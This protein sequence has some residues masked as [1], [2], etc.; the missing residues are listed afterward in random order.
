MMS[1]DILINDVIP[2][3]QYI[4]E[5][6][7]TDFDY[8]FPILKAADLG[9]YRTAND[10]EPDDAL[11][12]LTLNSDYTV[13]GEGEDAGGTVSMLI[14]IEAGDRITLQREM[15]YERLSAY[16]SG[17]LFNADSLD[18]DL[19]SVI[20][21]MQQVHAYYEKRFLRYENTILDDTANL[22]LPT[23]DEG[24]IW[25]KSVDGIAAVTLEENPNWSALRSE[26][27]NQGV[28]VDGSRIVG[29]QDSTIGSTTV[30]NAIQAYVG[31]YGVDTGTTN[32]I[33]ITLPVFIGYRNGMRVL[34]K[35]ANTNT[36]PM[37]ININ[38]TGVKNIKLQ[39]GE[40]TAGNAVVEDMI[41]ELVYDSDFGYFILMNSFETHSDFE[42]GD[43]KISSRAA[44]STG[45]VIMNDGTIGSANSAATTLKSDACK[46]LFIHLWNTYSDSLAPVTGGRGANAEADW[47]AD[48]DIKLLRVAGR[49]IVAAGQGSGLTNR[50]KGTIFGVE[51]VGLTLGQNGP[52]SHTWSFCG[53]ERYG[54]GFGVV[55]RGC[56]F[57]CTHY[58]LGKWRSA[59]K[60][61]AQR[62]I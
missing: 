52:H 13:S 34:V 26:L 16:K 31:I 43:V 61:A 23:L 2:K 15:P 47:L 46:A 60:H 27:A 5:E 19:N 56:W 35:I 14:E 58:N 20:M 28:G 25:K 36:G 1:T 21:M 44:A 12:K 18:L 3:L 38:S 22:R 39:N 29:Y 53:Y 54:G 17:R 40:D 48:K 8:T 6:G 4:A 59:R 62:C 51:T 57:K 7:Q 24:Q 33:L 32:N 45:W 49:A 9:V 30:H 41:A 37:T 11:Q 50:V 42:T 10:Q 55:R